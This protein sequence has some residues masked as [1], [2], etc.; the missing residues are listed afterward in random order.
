MML[1]ALIA[2]YRKDHGLSLDELSD[3]IGIDRMALWRLENDKFKQFKQWPTI[4]QWVFSG[5]T[6]STTQTKPSCQK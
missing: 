5:Q 6:N 1:G 4:L 2:S 3:R